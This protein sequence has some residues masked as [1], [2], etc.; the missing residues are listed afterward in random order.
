M[1]ESEDE[2]SNLNSTRSSLVESTRGNNQDEMSGRGNCSARYL[3]NLND[4]TDNSISGLLNNPIKSGY[5]LRMTHREHNAEN[6]IY[7]LEINRFK[8]LVKD[9]EAWNDNLSYKVIDSED[10]DFGRVK[11][12][13]KDLVIG[14]SKNSDWPSFKVPFAAFKQRVTHIWNTY[15]A[16]SAETQICMPAKVLYNTI[17]RLQHLE[18]YGY[19]V[20]DETIID[21][22]KTLN[23][24]VLPRFLASPCYRAMGKRLNELYPLPSKEMLDLKL[25]SKSGCMNWHEDRLT[26]D[27]LRNIK[28]TDI[29]HD[30][31]LYNEFL[32]HSKK[33][34]S[35]ENVFLARA[36]AI[37][38]SNYVNEIDTAAIKKGL[39]PP[40]VEAHA[41]LIF[42]FF[43]APN[44]CFEVGMNERRR[45]EIMQRL[46]SPTKD[47]FD[48]LE[49]STLRLIRNQYVTF[50]FTRE[51]RGIPAA[52]IG[53]EF[54]KQLKERA[55]K[56]ERKTQE[57]KRR[58]ALESSCLGLGVYINHKKLADTKRIY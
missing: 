35:E 36:I 31:L 58:E 19:K 2:L 46:A 16:V 21:P 8:D 25:P 26:V 44:S 32:N 5:L 9:T 52:I 42:K 14:C 24:D 51:F 15:L 17:Y 28:I 20:F 49:R 54:D 13:E 7:V 45:K 12:H 48:G 3:K 53:A 50:S 47:M 10:E 56:L 23:V 29:F 57:R 43:V 55:K 33:I 6:M 4:M 39:F 18:K 11:I 38:K 30:R 41:W 37:Y 22:I 1:S 34:Y 27:N 40:W